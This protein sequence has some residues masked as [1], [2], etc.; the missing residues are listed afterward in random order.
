MHFILAGDTNRLNLKS[1]LNIS[2]KLKQLVSVPTR[3]NPDAILDTIITTLGMYYQSPV[4]LP[5]LD[6][7]SNVSGKPSDHLIVLMKPINANEPKLKLFKTVTFRPLPESGLSQF[8]VW[9]KTQKWESV[10]GVTTAHEKANNLQNL[11]LENLDKFLPQ[12]TIRICSEDQ[13][14]FSSKLKK[15]DR[16]Q[17][18]EY[19]KHKK[20]EKWKALSE[21]YIRKCKEEKEK[22]YSDIVEDLKTSKPGQWYSKLKRMTSHD[23]AKSEEPN[24]ISFLGI[25]DQ[26][27]AEQIAS[28]F[29]EISNIY[30]P[31][32]TDDISLEGIKNMKPYPLMEPYLV[33]RKIKKM[34]SNSA[35]VVGDIP[36]KV[37][38]MFAYELSLPLS[39]VYKRSCK[40]GEYPDIWKMETV[41]PAPKVYPPQTANDLRKI[42]GTLNFSKI[43]EKF[44]AEAMISDMTPTSDPSQYGNEKGIGT[45]H[46]LI[47]MIDRILTCLDTNNSLCSHL[48]AY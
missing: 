1:I 27:Q 20:S 5:P 25:S 8:G 45:Q 28:Q 36:I 15:V 13:P 38:K 48:S 33:H 19:T 21:D 10:M 43:F 17:K 7:D 3:R 29:S 9:I 16:R 42:S 11:L 31:L 12:K 23:Q 37:I 44:L 30:E 34:K 47:K 26:S 14:W 41:T 40:F 46:Y 2:P 18:R 22:Y 39:D 35:T 32:K 4:T 6:N 24:V